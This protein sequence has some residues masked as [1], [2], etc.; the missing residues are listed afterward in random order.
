MIELRP[1]ETPTELATWARIKSTVLPN[2]PVT[3]ELLASTA[4]PDRLLLL[5]SLDGI[6]AGCGVGALSS[7]G[8]RA[9]CAAR[10][11][12]PY[13]RRGIGSALYRALAEHG[14]SL[15]RA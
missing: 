12:E 5:A 8:G 14:R 1:A 9:F 10:V 15:G 2:E 6:D 13:R 3:P 11:L 4:E 7:F